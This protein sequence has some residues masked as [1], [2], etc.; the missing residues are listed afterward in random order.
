VE[1]FALQ[2]TGRRE[3]AREVL[4]GTNKKI[5]RAAVEPDSSYQWL[6][7][8]LL[9]ASILDPYRRVAVQNGQHTNAKHR[10]E[11]EIKN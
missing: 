3:K 11:R 7:N 10:L 2:G 9:A 6:Y 5:G 4:A 1:G 8:N